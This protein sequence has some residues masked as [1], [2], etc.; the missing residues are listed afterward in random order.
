[1]KFQELI[2]AVSFLGAPNLVL[3]ENFSK[4][5]MEYCDDRVSPLG[6]VSLEERL[7]DLRKRYSHKSHY[8]PEKTRCL[9][10]GYEA[11]RKTNFRKVQN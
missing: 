4:K 9:R 6:V 1:M 2:N 5:I 8:T 7:M 10:S 3:G 11:N